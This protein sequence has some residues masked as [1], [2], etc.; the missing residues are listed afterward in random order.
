MRL[1][2]LAGVLVLVAASPLANATITGVNCWNDSNAFT[3]NYWSWD[4]NTTTLWMDESLHEYPAIVYTDFT[5]N[6]PEDPRPEIVKD[7]DNDTNFAWTDYHIKVTRNQ[8]FTI[9]TAGTPGSDWTNTIIPVS[10]QGSDYVG[11]ID[12]FAGTPIPVGGSGHFQFKVSFSNDAH[13]IIQQV[14]TPEPASLSLLA[15]GGLML[16]RRKRK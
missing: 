6:S 3:M 7:V 8:P 4:A 2:Y 5:V 14:P 1:C 9:D 10:L 15:V 13:F 16:L 12:Y 11:E